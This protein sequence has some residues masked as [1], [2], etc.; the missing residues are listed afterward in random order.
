MA[1]QAVQRRLAAVLAAD[2]A[3][4]TR[5][6]EQDTDGTVSAWQAA[7]DDVIRPSVESHSGKIVKLTGDG[8]LVE[9]SSVQNAVSCAIA[10][11]EGLAAGS[12]KFRMGI[13]LGDII[14][15]GED[16]HGEGVNIAARIEALADP[17]GI[18]ISGGVY[19]QVRNRIDAQYEDR[20]EHEVKHVT[21]PVRVYAIQTNTVV[22]DE[23]DFAISEKTAP[24][25]DL[26][27][28][29]VIAVLPFTDLSGD[30][31]QDYFADGITEDLI[32]TLSQI[33][34]LSVVSRNSTFTFKGLNPSAAE[35]G[36]KLNAGFVVSGSLRKSGTRIRITAQLTNIATDTQL[37]ADRYDR[38]MEDIFAVQD[39]ITLT[40][41]TALQVKLTEGEQAKLRYTTTDNVKAWSS[42]IR[43]L[44][45]FRTVSA[46]T[47]R[48][49]RRCFEDALNEDPNSAQIH[50][51]LACVHAIEGR[52]YWTSDRE[53]SLGQAKI[54]ADIALAADTETAD[55][56]AALGYW[57]M[58]YSRLD[59][60]VVA[61][62]RAVELAP[63]HADLHALH[64]LALTFAERPEDGVREAELAMTLNPLDPGWYY[65]VLGHAYRYAGRFDDAL[66]ILLEYNRL[67]PTFGLVDLTLTCADMGKMDEARRYGKALLAARPDFTVENW[68]LT[69]NCANPQRL[70]DDRK[71]LIDAGLT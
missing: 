28:H 6:M 24:K 4:Y 68:A 42:F 14:D 27:S 48:Q 16:I 15:D 46:D 65:G 39:E 12:L 22:A 2:V 3:G 60:S 36:E 19:E 51:M 66:N 31:D 1:D 34:H 38:D 59:D 43:G 62:A 64:A 13:N 25:N 32:T 52:F 63:D 18:S 33:G 57:H 23:R 5:L 55:A 45:L 54:H 44:S 61:Y 35:V 50:A 37:W 21:A 30:P 7:R 69:Q 29:P 9:F 56:W 58:G 41:A 17:G 53:G 67:S 8:F 10:L 11:Q 70:I 49:A 26:E 71:S 40:I 47:Y 20:G